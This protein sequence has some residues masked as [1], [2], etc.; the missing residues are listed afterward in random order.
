MKKYWRCFVCNDIHY[1]IKPPTICPTCQVKNAY[2]ETSSAEAEI[3]CITKKEKVDFDKDRFR[4]AIEK[5]AEKNEF[6]VNP[7]R[8]KVNMLLEGIFNNEKN[9]GLK[10]CPCRLITKDFEEDLKLVCP[11]NFLAHDT[12]REKGECW[13]GLFVRRK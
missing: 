10:Y 4:E 3:T 13:C 2:I 11:C 6:E 12:Y 8:E 1:G 9:Q 7:D 5:F